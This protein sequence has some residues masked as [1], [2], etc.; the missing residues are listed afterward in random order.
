M[1]SSQKII[2]SLGLLGLGVC[3]WFGFRPSLPQ[4][5]WL[6]VE[7]QRTVTIGQPLVLRVTTNATTPAGILAVDLHWSNARR[8]SRGM[9]SG[10]TSQRVNPGK[11]TL[12]YYLPVPPRK[13]MAYVRAIIYTGPTRRWDTR[14]AA[15]T[16]DPIWIVSTKERSPQDDE[17]RRLAVYD[18]KPSPSAI[19]QDSPTV[20]AVIAILWMVGVVRWWQRGTGFLKPGSHDPKSSTWF[21]DRSAALACLVAATWEALPIEERFGQWARAYA[22]DHG[23]YGDRA[24]YQ[25]V[26]TCAIVMG[27]A[28]LSA[29]AWIRNRDWSH[30]FTWLGLGA[31]AGLTLASLLSLHQV[32]TLLAKTVLTLSALQCGQVSAAAIAI[33]GCS[34]AR[35]ATQPET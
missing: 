4:A 19:R 7:A 14:T 3:T 21:S 29:I 1:L 5:E 28:G 22:V 23:W 30:R 9:L 25:L 34:L 8:E 10:A 13:D 24:P 15:A 17:L 35:P 26:L 6:T 2:L 20:Q 27:A 11:T 12:T 16:S 18:Q 33:V 32:D 31:Y